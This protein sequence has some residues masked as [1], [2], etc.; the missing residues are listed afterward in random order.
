MERRKWRLKKVGSVCSCYLIDTLLAK[1][2][3]ITS[4]MYID[5]DR[6]TVAILNTHEGAGA[7]NA[8]E[9]SSNSFD[10]TGDL[11]PDVNATERGE[12]GLPWNEL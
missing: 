1:G 2:V 9:E 5:F 7:C 3:F 11:Q 12:L 6:R 8:S 10:L 4:S